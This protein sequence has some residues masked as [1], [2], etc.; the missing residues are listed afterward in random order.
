MV[1]LLILLAAFA[2]S[3]YVVVPKD[4]G[5]DVSFYCVTSRNDLEILKFHVSSLG[6]MYLT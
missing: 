2:F 4:G 3:L 1:I 5:E 6:D